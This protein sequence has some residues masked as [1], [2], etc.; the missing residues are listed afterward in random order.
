MS[1]AQ[2]KTIDAAN[3]GMAS[4][5]EAA[6]AMPAT[7]LASPGILDFAATA[8]AFQIDWA[9]YKQSHFLDTDG[10]TLISQLAACNDDAAICTI[11]QEKG[12]KL[13][14]VLI[15][16]L[17]KV[18]KLETLQYLLTSLITVIECSPVSIGLFHKSA[19]NSG[20]P[21][22]QAFLRILSTKDD[23]YVVHQAARVIIAVTTDGVEPLPQREQQVF[24]MWICNETK[25][26]DKDASLL[27]LKSLCKF[28]RC[29]AYRRS[30]YEHAEGV[31]T[32]KHIF[33]LEST[34]NIQAQYL[35]AFCAWVVTFDPHVA[36]RLEDDGSHL[37]ADAA[38]LLKSSK[39]EKVVRMCLGFFANLL[40]IPTK[41]SIRKRNATVMITLKLLPAVE[42][43]LAQGIVDTEAIENA[44]MLKEQLTIY[45]EE[46]ST[47]DEYSNEVTCGRLEWSPVH[48]SERFWRENAT[49]LNSD[50]HK[51]LKILI[52]LLEMSKD[53]QILAVA[54]H[55]IGQ[56]VRFY[57]RGKLTLEKLKGKTAIMKLMTHSDQSVRY[58]ALLAVQKMMTQNWSSLGMNLQKT[59]A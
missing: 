29:T 20:V 57:P 46:M 44:E 24:F 14:D 1:S 16:L 36:D 28:L 15:G 52:Q 27:A 41:P 38:A 53:P 37:T 17:S 42:S 25:S 9:T 47:F 51:L 19:A 40:K 50:K 12:E 3:A 45:Y 7:E 22:W 13:F 33:R 26:K 23:P 21:S 35:A 31:S 58:E 30:F 59:Q 6:Y 48:R 32:L 2:Y 56:Y 34:T 4:A 5:D 8:A 39:K 49:A 18:S 54:A 43:I 11:V 55:D 10:H